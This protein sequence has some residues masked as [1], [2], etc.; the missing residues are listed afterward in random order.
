MGNKQDES[1]RRKEKHKSPS[2]GRGAASA[3]EALIKRRVTSPD[4]PAQQ[5]ELP[6]SHKKH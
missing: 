5:T 3:M 4:Q 1:R 6:P 2:T